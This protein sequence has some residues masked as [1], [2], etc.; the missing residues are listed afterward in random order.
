MGNLPKGITRKQKILHAIATGDTSDLPE[1]ITRKEKILHAIASGDTSNIPEGITR[2][3]KI[4]QCIAENGGSG[5]GTERSLKK[6]LDFTKK[7]D[8][9]FSN[10][11]DVEKIDSDIIEKT[12]TSNVTSMSYMFSGCSA[13]QEVPELDTSNVTSMMNMFAYSPAVQNIPQ[14]DTRKVTDMCGMFMNCSSLQ[15]VPELDTSNVTTMSQTFANCSSLKTIPELDIRNVARLDYAFMGCSAL[16]TCL[17]KNIKLEDGNGEINFSECPNLT[18]ETLIH[19]IK[20]LRIVDVTSYR[21]IY[22]ATTTLAKLADVYVKTITIT[23]EMRAED[24]LIDEKL[25]FEVCESTDDGAMLIT[26]YVT[27]KNWE[28]A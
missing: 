1:G 7:A 14:Y 5:G 3:E 25:P 20:E 17:I 18:K 28:L 9:L 12:D 19:I 11:S 10:L 23:D 26:N 6:L 15:E 2:E 16:E 24:D 27:N 13:L 22:L 21:S 8:S 4:L